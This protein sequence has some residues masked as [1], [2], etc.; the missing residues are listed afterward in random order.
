[1]AT[2]LVLDDA[3]T[4]AP[5]GPAEIRAG[6]LLDDEEHDIATLK[7]QGVAIVAYN[8]GTMGN[9]LDAFRRSRQPSSL[10]ALLLAD[11]VL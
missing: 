7:T 4:G 10:V 1:M 9:A 3:L 5:S 11:G 8:P 6:T 2:Y